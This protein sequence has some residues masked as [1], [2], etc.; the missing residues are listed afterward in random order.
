MNVW[1]HASSSAE[2]RDRPSRVASVLLRRHA[3][4]NIP[5]DWQGAFVARFRY[6]RDL[7][8]VKIGSASA[9]NFSGPA[10]R[11]PF[12]R[13]ELDVQRRELSKWLLTAAGAALL[14]RTLVFSQSRTPPSRPLTPGGSWIDVREYGV[15]ANSPGAA[16]ANTRALQALL[17]PNTSGPAGLVVFPNTAGH[18]VY[19]FNGVIPLRD[20]V[21]IELMGSTVRYS[22]K[23]LPGDVNSG[24]FFALRDFSCQNGTIEVA[25]DTSAATGSGHALQIG[26]RG[27]DS[28]HFTVWD[29]QLRVPM[30]NIQLRNLRIN[31]HNSGANQAGCA[32][33]GVLGGVQNLIA[34]NIMIDGGGTLILGVY[35]EFGWATNEPRADE[36]Q[37][38]H[39]H[40]M[41]F[42][43]IV[44][45][46][47]DRANGLAMTLAGAY[48]CEV[49]GLHV[50]GGKTAFLAY[51]GESMFYRPWAGVDNSGVGHAI[52]LR[53]VV[54]QSLSST[55]VAF[56]GA[57]KASAGYLRSLFSKVH[58]ASHAAETNLGD[59]SLDGFALAGC[60]GFG[61]LTSAGR[62]I[63]RNGS[64]SA[65]QRGIVATDECVSL[66][67]E[68]VDILRSQQQGVQLDFGVAMWDPPRSKK[69]RIEDCH[70]A[71]NGTSAAGRFAGIEIGNCDSAL[72]ENCRLGY[73][74]G[75]DG[76]SET[77]QGDA[78]RV[79]GAGSSNVI[80]RADHV[81]GVAG[82]DAVAYRGGS[83]GDANGNTIEQA[84]GITSAS[85]SWIKRS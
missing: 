33:I 3:I 55:A 17:D 48:G 20:G 11:L 53:N 85:G 28:S 19:H 14:P 4:A 24:L 45:Q 57:Q 23:A 36:R 25:C 42:S 64:I 12:G 80:C 49:D 62:A 6:H 51:P 67:I 2:T 68:G 44:V 66:I 29:S 69:V 37:T 15:V 59:F 27:T 71:G 78:V 30:G 38:S 76:T 54:A 7:P 84:T 5:A 83:G 58:S 21:S 13:R 35:Y 52:L 39:A 77:T 82:S 81:G 56:T 18:D 46:N 60:A 16:T 65:C 41:H 31:I 70:I 9:L 79:S 8:K 10:Q 73:E 74:M 1:A 43:N 72:I 40:N 63:I 50:T 32:A 26:A 22:G 61:I 75:F 47:L 34:D